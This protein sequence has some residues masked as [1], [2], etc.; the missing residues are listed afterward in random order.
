MPENDRSF[1]AVLRMT[2][3]A[4]VRG[5]N[6]IDLKAILHNDAGKGGLWNFASDVHNKSR[7]EK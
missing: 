6:S 4:G 5:R 7:L 1:F 2:G 3:C